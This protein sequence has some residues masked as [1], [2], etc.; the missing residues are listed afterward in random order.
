M[1]PGL[2][3]LNVLLVEDN[4]DDVATVETIIQLSK[5][6]V[7][8]TVARTGQ[9]ALDILTGRL[10]EDVPLPN[11]VL[12]DLSLPGLTGLEVLQLIKDVPALVDTPVI[13]LTG[14]TDDEHV[15]AGEQ[16]GAH[17]QLVKPLRLADFVWITNAV[18]RYGERLASLA[19]MEK[20][21]SA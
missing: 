10:S 8:L 7:R 6:D 15:R 5:L 13:L 20:R 4:D 3:R 14:S 18:A 9:A 12:L 11:M 21:H 19:Q 1:Q 17:S 16:F 2:D